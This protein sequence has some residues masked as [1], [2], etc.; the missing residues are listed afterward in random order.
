MDNT[1][2]E[3]PKSKVAAK[4]TNPRVLVIYSKPKAG[5]TS[6]FAGLENNLILDLEEGS[7]FLEALKVKISGYKDILDIGKKIKEANCPYKYITIDTVTALEDM[8]KPLA[9][10]QYKNSTLGKNY[11][12]KNILELP[13][14]GGYLWLRE[15]F[16]NLISYVKSLSEYTILSGHIKDKQI[17]DNGATVAAANIDLTG[18]IKSLICANADSIGYLYRIGNETHISFKS[19]DEVTCG[20]R[21]PHLSNQDIIVAEMVNGELITHWDRIYL[22]ND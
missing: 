18:K 20:S 6:L 17:N 8:A 5:K 11:T 10:D 14:G 1:V 7:D 19:N 21:S 3:L 9:L 4:T 2:L 16:F 22:S 13:Q 15:A 12:G